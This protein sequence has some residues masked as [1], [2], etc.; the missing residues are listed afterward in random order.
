MSHPNFPLIATIGRR[1]RSL[2]ARFMDMDSS[3][4]G[5]KPTIYE[6]GRE[7]RSSLHD[8]DNHIHVLLWRTNNWA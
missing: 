3:Q 6:Q 4:E 2:I 1:Y 7:V 5:N 8:I